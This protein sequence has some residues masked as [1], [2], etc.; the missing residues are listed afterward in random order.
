MGSR[1]DWET[2]RHAVRDA[3]RARRPV[4][5]ARRLGPPDAGPALRVRGL[6]G[7][8]RPAGADRRRRRRGAPARDGGGEDGAARARRPGRVE[9]AEGDGLA[10]LDRA[11]AGRRAGRDARDRPGRAP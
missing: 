10:A 3:R 5:A 8:A 2:M 7:G 1:S 6:G 11:D 4:R 9:D